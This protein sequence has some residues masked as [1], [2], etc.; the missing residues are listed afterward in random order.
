[1][2]QKP[3]WQIQAEQDLEVLKELPIFTLSAAV[4]AA[5]AKA[6]ECKICG[7]D[8]SLLA[9]KKH[10]TACAQLVKDEPII[11]A[12]Y[13]DG[14]KP[15]N[16]EIERRTK[17]SS[18]DIKI[19]LKK[20]NLI[21]WDK[22]LE[23]EL[24]KSIVDLHS[25]GVSDRDLKKKLGIGTSTL[26]RILNRKN[27][28]MTSEYHKDIDQRHQEIVDNY[29]D[30]TEPTF[31]EIARRLDMSHQAVENY[32]KSLGLKSWSTIKKEK[33]NVHIASLLATG[34]TPHQICQQY[35]YY[36]RRVKD[37]SERLK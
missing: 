29:Y 28:K 33:E 35:G 32:L 2:V 4:I 8:F 22:R 9:F 11:L 19:I 10:E 3:E 13:N 34:L 16:Q 23:Q 14:T 5:R 18:H 26:T 25:K 7:K 36:F 21:S 24:E 30:G 37:L 31:T 20:N 1:M 6:Y 15:S 12:C 27:I 17:I